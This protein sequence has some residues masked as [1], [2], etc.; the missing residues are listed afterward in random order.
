MHIVAMLKKIMRFFNWLNYYKESA[1][2]VNVV[3]SINPQKNDWLKYM[4][5]NSGNVNVSI[6]RS[7]VFQVLDAAV[8]M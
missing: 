8:V 6:Q 1:F 3:S 7:E 2:T 4:G 5:I